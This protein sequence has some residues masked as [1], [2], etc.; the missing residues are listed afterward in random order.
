MEAKRARRR[1]KAKWKEENWPE[2]ENRRGKR[3]GS[4]GGKVKQCKHKRAQ[5]KGERKEKVNDYIAK[6]MG[7][8]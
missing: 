8:G 3:E 1:E 2:S 5:G 6:T 7:E 4:R